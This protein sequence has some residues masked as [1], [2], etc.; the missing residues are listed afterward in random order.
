M[1]AGAGTD[2]TAPNQQGALGLIARS[3]VGR[4]ALIVICVGLLAYALWKLYQGVFS[5]GRRAAAARGWSTGSATSAAVVAYLALLRRGLRVLA[6]SSGNSS[7]EPTQAAGG[8]LGWPGG[9]RI[10]GIAGA[11]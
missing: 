3:P 9:R 2:G 6:G 10:V 7:S 11:Y 5:S 1:P 4:V 8:V